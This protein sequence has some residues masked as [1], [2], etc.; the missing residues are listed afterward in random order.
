MFWEWPEDKATRNDIAGGVCRQS[1]DPLACAHY[2]RIMLPI[3]LLHPLT[4]VSNIPDH[5]KFGGYTTL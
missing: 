2:M 1:P 3:Q 5:F 4:N